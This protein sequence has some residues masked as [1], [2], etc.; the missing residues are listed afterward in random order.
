MSRFRQVCG[1]ETHLLGC[2]VIMFVGKLTQLSSNYNDVS[3]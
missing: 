1:M 2:V 3:W